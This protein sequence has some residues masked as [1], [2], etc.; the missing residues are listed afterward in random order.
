MEIS[1]KVS[2]TRWQ[3]CRTISKSIGLQRYFYQAMYF[4]KSNH[5]KP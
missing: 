4:L 1:K 3:I 5:L 2:E